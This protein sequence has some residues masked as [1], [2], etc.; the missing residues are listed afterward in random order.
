MS[1]ET[2]GRTGLV[3]GRSPG[4]GGVSKKKAS[5]PDSGMSNNQYNS[6][7]KPAA[8]STA[9]PDSGEPSTKKGTR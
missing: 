8:G 5:S 4:S 7:G 2:Q 1:F 3:S 9:T 6:T